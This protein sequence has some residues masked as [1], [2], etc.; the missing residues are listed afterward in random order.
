MAE[1]PLKKLLTIHLGHPL[2]PSNR[3]ADCGGVPAQRVCDLPPGEGRNRCRSVAQERSGS[4]DALGSTPPRDEGGRDKGATA[5]PHQELVETQGD[6]PLFPAGGFPGE[7][8]L[9]GESLAA[10]D[11]LFPHRVMLTWSESRP[12]TRRARDGGSLDLRAILPKPLGFRKN[13]VPDRPNEDGTAGRASR[14]EPGLSVHAM[15]ASVE[16][17]ARPYSCGKARAAGS[18]ETQR[19][20]RLAEGSRGHIREGRH[21]GSLPARYG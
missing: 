15:G 10:E 2:R 6:R 8:N 14:T 3:P 9:L 7:R 18:D 16:T 19:L 20:A 11:P 13:R 21:T 4:I 5:N 1:D 12:A 17:V